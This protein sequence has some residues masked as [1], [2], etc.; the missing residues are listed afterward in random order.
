MESMEEQHATQQQLPPPIRTGIAA[1]LCSDNL[2]RHARHHPPLR[3]RDMVSEGRDA[4]PQTI[5]LRRHQLQIEEAVLLCNKA[6]PSSGDS[7]IPQIST[8]RGA[9]NRVLSNA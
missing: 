7:R 2:L 8:S 9:A 1:C 6:E 3:D 4:A 5:L